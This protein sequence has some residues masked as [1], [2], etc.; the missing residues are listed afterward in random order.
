MFRLAALALAALT[1][2][3]SAP[4]AIVVTVN[5]AG[6]TSAN[7]SGYTFG[8]ANLDNV[9]N[10]PTSFN[11]VGSPITGTTMDGYINIGSA[12]VYGGAGGSGQF[13][14][15]YGD[16]ATIQLSQS[17]NYFGL[18]GSALD[19]NNSV[20]LYNDNTLLG[21]YALQSV[22]QASPGF[23]SGY[24]GN[25]SGGGNAGELYAFFNFASD[26]AF[27]RVQLI[28]N[29]GGGFEFDNLT[30]GTSVVSTAPEP[31][32]WAMFLMGFG[33][34]GGFLRQRRDRVQ[35]LPLTA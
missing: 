8:V 20:A 18:W 9:S 22:L 7:L 6:S 31:A 13:A 1:W 28:Q 26:S 29:G 4:A 35:A 24:Y 33:L 21:T 3:A 5:A 15:L 32:T 34:V 27:N 12:N 23:N 16:P 25:P 10:G 19:G 11:F 17:V 14:S 30:V 2:A